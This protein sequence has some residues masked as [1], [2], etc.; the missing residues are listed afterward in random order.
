MKQLKEDRPFK[1]E[2]PFIYWRRGVWLSICDYV[3]WF[4]FICVIIL[5]I[6]GLYSKMVLN[7]DI[8]ETHQMLKNNLNRERFYDGEGN[9]IPNNIVHLLV[10]SQY[11]VVTKAEQDTLN[12][13][14]YYTKTP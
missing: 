13:Y 8:V 14:F 2:H 7:N 10:N 11:M 9:T 1:E 4:M 12:R 5:V 3:Y 6:L